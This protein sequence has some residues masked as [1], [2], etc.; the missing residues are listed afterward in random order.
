MAR[1]SGK[2]VI[3]TGAA[4]GT[5]LGLA[6]RRAA[7]EGAHVVLA[8]VQEEKGRAAADALGAAARFVRLDVG[9][10]EDWARAVRAAQEAF[11][12]LDGLVNNAA[13]LWMGSIEGTPAAEMER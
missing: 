8:D 11:G 4:Q 12:R 10:E 3:G 9:K 6:P 7:A 5:G 13:V 1:L 2:V